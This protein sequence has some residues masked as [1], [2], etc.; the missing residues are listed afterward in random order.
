M[1]VDWL[2][3]RHRRA[4]AALPT[5]VLPPMTLRCLCVS[6]LAAAA[7][8]SPTPMPLRYCCH[9]AIPATARGAASTV[10][11]TPPP[12]PGCQA[13]RHLRAAAAVAPALT[14]QLPPP[15]DYPTPPRSSRCHA[16]ATA[17][18]SPPPLQYSHYRCCQ[19]IPSATVLLLHC[20]R[21]AVAGVAVSSLLPTS[22]PSMIFSQKNK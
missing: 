13:G 6:K 11:A 17:A 19:A 5:A 2:C 14:P 7:V 20:C 4:A 16:T 10:A 3:R 9:H 22:L 21:H 1:I 8:L 15:S 18:I 12:L